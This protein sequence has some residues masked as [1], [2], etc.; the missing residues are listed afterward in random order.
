MAA[1]SK[2]IKAFC[3]GCCPVREDCLD[4]ACPFYDLRKYNEGKVIKWW[5]LPKKQ[6]EEAA[7]QARTNKVLIEA[8]ISEPTE[9]QIA[10]RKKFGEM[11]KKEAKKK[12]KARG[13]KK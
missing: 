3:F 6:W 2:R 12:K 10:H 4:T 13:K 8:D 1:Y 11:K 5:N 7:Y 9:A